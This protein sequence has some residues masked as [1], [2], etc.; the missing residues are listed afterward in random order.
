[1]SA[2]ELAVGELVRITIDAR[3]RERSDTRLEFVVGDGET[4]W[5]W[6]DMPGVTIERVDPVGWPPQPGDEWE[7]DKGKPWFVLSRPYGGHALRGVYDDTALW[8]RVDEWLEAHRP[9]RLIRR[10]PSLPVLSPV[11]EDR[12]AS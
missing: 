8:L 10:R 5:V 12:E 11:I 9:A 7:D 6:P 3:L 1:V 2:P 4:L